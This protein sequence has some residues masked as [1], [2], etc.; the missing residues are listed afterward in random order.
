MP[1][2]A[3]IATSP[4]PPIAD[5]IPLNAIQGTYPLGFASLQCVELTDPSELARTPQW[6]QNFW[7]AE[8]ERKGVA[9]SGGYIYEVQLAGPFNRVWVAA[10]LW[11]F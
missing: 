5:R 11:G 1:D 6:S 3:F 8:A 2:Q 9:S 10:I 4:T 7:A